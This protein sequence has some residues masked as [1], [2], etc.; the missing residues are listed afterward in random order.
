MPEQRILLGNGATELI[1]FLSRLFPSATLALPVFSEFVRAFPHARTADLTDSIT[2]LREG[3][4]VLT[5]PANPTGWTLPLDTLRAYLRSSNATVLIDESFIE[6]SGRPSSATLLEEFPNL[7]VLRSLTKLYA[8]PGLRIGALIGHVQQW[9]DQREPWQVNVLAQAAAL[10]AISDT[11]HAARSIQFVS[12][13]RE[14]LSRHLDCLPSDANFLFV[15]LDCPG[16]NL[17]RQLLERKILI[18]DDAD[19]RGV[20]IAVRTR[21]ENDRL[22]DAWREFRP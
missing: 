22:L 14:Y 1:F 4:L 19:W 17:K 11:E 16:A 12:Q 20:R 3:L 21:A 15:P 5:R 6:F 2:W 9:R 18:R 8:L 10:A 13:E 7:L